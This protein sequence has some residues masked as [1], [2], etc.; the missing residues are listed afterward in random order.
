MI[1]FK[2]VGDNPRKD[3]EVTTDDADAELIRME[4][5]FV[6]GEAEHMGAA[7]NLKDASH[8][9][10][11]L[12]FIIPGDEAADVADILEEAG[13]DG[14]WTYLNQLNKQNASASVADDD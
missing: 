7:L 10:A 4:D 14:L 11:A 1:E 12:S 3:I 9:G 8:D 2:A 6:E 5:A 13:I